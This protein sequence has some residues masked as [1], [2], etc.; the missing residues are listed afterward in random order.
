MGLAMIFAVMIQMPTLRSNDDVLTKA[1]SIDEEQTFE[2][3]N[4]DI[5]SST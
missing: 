4:S 1:D 5:E 2:M 3:R